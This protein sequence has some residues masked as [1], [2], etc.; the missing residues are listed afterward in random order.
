MEG[1]LRSMLPF[2]SQFS[3]HHSTEP[4]WDAWRGASVFASDAVLFKQS[5][6]TYEEYCESGADRF[7]G[8]VVSNVW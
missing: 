5:A 3:V 4:H 1:E 2:Q 7:G 6:I 8:S